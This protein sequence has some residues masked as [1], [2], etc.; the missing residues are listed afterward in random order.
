MHTYT[1]FS[2]T[3]YLINY[4]IPEVTFQEPGRECVH[5]NTSNPEGNVL[6]FVIYNF[7]IL[8]NKIRMVCIQRS[9]SDLIN[10]L[11][12]PIHNF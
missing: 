8:V 1:D 11:K 7:K 3:L 12:L 10:K 2:L 4:S 9:M 5:G 6:F